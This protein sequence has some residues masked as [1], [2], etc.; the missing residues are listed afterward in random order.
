MGSNMQRQAVPLLDPDVPIVSTGM[1]R[2]AA[3]DSGQVI[4][5]DEEG[6]VLSV[7]GDRIEMRRPDGSERIYRLRKYQRSNQSTNI[8]QRPIVTK[9]QRVHPGDIIA[10][11]S[12]TYNGELALGHDVLAAFLSWDGGNY[13]DA[14]LISERLVREDKFTSI[15]I[16]KHEVEA[17]DTKLG[18]EEITFDI[19]NVGEDALKDLDERGIVRVGAEVGPNDILVGK[20]TPKGEKELSPEE[21]LLAIFVFPRGKD[22][23]ALPHGER[24]SSRCASLTAKSIA[25]FPQVKLQCVS[26]LRSAASSPGDTQIPRELRHYLKS[27]R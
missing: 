22:P 15:H 21:K 4:T 13:E 24:V 19:P 16:E 25:T 23:P 26:P 2:H 20:I 14:I 8:D 6:E 9:G 10:D 1:E 3:R 11:S 27:Y 12:S 5:A 18:P 7:T 17:R